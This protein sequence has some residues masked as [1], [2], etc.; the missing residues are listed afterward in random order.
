MEPLPRA[1]TRDSGAEEIIMMMVEE[2]EN[3]QK[4]VEGLTDY[5]CY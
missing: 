5:V 2:R 3:Y 4:S 1:Y